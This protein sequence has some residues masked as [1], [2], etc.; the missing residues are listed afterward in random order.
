MKYKRPSIEIVEVEYDI[1]TLSNV[2][3][4]DENDIVKW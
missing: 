2:E 4:E 3:V 1:V